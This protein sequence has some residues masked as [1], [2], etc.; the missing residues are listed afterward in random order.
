MLFVQWQAHAQPADIP[1]LKHTMLRMQQKKDFCKDSAYI[2]ILDSLAFAFYRI[3]ADSLFFYSQ[4]ALDFAQQAGYG[5]GVSVSIRIQGN[6]YA[7]TGNYVKMLASYQQALTI[8]EKINDPI[9]IAKATVNIAMRY[10][11]IGKGDESMKLFM[12]AADI[13]EKMKDSLN[14]QKAITGIGVTWSQKKQYD[15][16]LRYHQKA[17]DIA[18]A[19]KDDYSVVVSNDN[20][21]A[22]LFEQA[23]YKE[24]LDRFLHTREYFSHTDDKIRKTR[25]D[26]AIALTYFQLKNY[27]ATIEYANQSL[28]SATEIKAK[29]LIGQSDK[30]LADVYDAKNDARNALKYFKLYKDIS[31][32]LFNETMLKKTGEL[33]ARFEYEKRE[34][35]LK[36][37]QEKKNALHKHIVRN[38]ELQ[39]SIATLV[40]L[41]LSILI[42]LLFRSRAAKHKTNQLLEAKNEEIERQA[43]QLHLKTQEKDKL[44]SIISHDLKVPL[45][46]L[47]NM[48][49][50]LK[51]HS[52]PEA[53][54]QSIINEFR[55]DIDYSAELTSNL[56]SWASSQLDG[57]III[58]VMLPVHELVSGTMEPLIKTAADKKV[59]LINKV[60]QPLT[61]W[62]DQNMVQVLIR[63][64]ISN[65]IKFC[66]PGDVI[67]IEG[68]AKDGIVEICVADT[69]I[70][71]GKEVLT[72]INRKESVTTFGTANEKGVGLGMLLCH[73][74]AEANRGIFRVESEPGKGS[75]FYFTLPSIPDLQ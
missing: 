61:V 16:A 53:D 70:G 29:R 57:R 18:T 30:I 28:Q 43:V 41:F 19:M 31:D 2:D 46:S 42:F 72:K 49:E 59:E 17:L 35:Q 20:I 71:I 65:A 9:C 73:E 60:P 69:G 36:K 14:W 13:F 67:T 66:N 63:N 56:L 64:L 1:R 47:K 40:I 54:L 3:S 55:R 25:A 45:Y 39:I 8:A 21:G 15:K 48:L 75:R 52:L 10:S 7:L 22:V 62:A 27:P 38:K 24:A 26:V 44:F 11:D 4:K 68:R 50:I 37:D 51:E 6:G 33:E 32:S 34:T 5:K 74:F 23:K 12:K 58:P